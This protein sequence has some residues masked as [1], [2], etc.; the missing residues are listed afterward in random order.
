M[1]N[2]IR[3]YI[4]VAAT[5]FFIIGVL[6]ILISLIWFAIPFCNETEIVVIRW[7]I[8][9]AITIILLITGKLKIY[10]PK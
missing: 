10:H 2:K 4:S 1:Y 3:K 6:A 7:Y 5:L 8:A 9:S